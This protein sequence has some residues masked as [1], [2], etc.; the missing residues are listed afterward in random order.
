MPS[1]RRATYLRIVAESKPNKSEKHRVRFTIGGN[2]INYPGVITTPTVEI[3]TVKLHLNSVISNVNVSYLVADIKV[4]YLNTPM[5][6]FKYMRIP[7]KHIPEDIMFQYALQSLVVNGYVLV[8]IRKGRYGLPQIGL[9]AQKRLNAHLLKFG[10]KKYEHTPGLYAHTTRV[11]GFTLVVDDFGIKCCSK[12]DALQLVTCLRAL[13][14]ITTNWTGS[15]YI[16]FTLEWNYK[17][18]WVELSTP[19]YI[20]RTLLRFCIPPLAKPQYLPHD[21]L[22]PSYGAKFQMT[23]SPDTSKILD[24]DGKHRIQEVP[25]TGTQF[26]RLSIA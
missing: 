15:P 18:R 16:G 14:E 19:G 26:Y 13:Y 25:R 2:R 8:E 5:N 17:K 6:R 7:V 9:I 3:Q 12:D 10:N 24:A 21:W 20:E 11:T 1:D 4:F 23:Q 22:P